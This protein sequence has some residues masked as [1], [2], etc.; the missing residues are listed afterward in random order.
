MNFHGYISTIICYTQ[1]LASPNIDSRITMG[2]ET[3]IKALLSTDK[4]FAV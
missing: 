1:P 2:N 4:T 3:L